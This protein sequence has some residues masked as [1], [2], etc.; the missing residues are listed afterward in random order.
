MTLRQGR[1]R[2]RIRT[3]FLGMNSCRHSQLV[4][5]SE[6]RDRVR[7]RHCHLTIAL[8]ELK[9]GWCPECFED[10]GER[11][12]DFEKIEA[13]ETATVRYRCEECGAIIESHTE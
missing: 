9:K 2:R 10:S 4:L 8:D 1:R 3:G 12:Y 7:C 13:P 11:R 5:L 6:D